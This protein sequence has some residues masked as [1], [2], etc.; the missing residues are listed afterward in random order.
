[1]QDKITVWKYPASSMEAS[2]CSDNC[3]E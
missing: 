3:K 2:Q 1:M